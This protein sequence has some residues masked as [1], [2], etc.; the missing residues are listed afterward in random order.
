[1]T[2]AEA[3]MPKE[4][5]RSDDVGLIVM[6]F[7]FSNIACASIGFIAVSI[8]SAIASADDAPLA[9]RDRRI[10]AL[11]ESLASPNAEPQR[12]EPEKG[13]RHGFFKQFPA[14]YDHAAQK[15]VLEAVD[16]LVKEGVAAFPELVAHMND[17]RY[18]CT[19]KRPMSD[20][21]HSVGYVCREILER[22]TYAHEDYLKEGLAVYLAHPDTRWPE[23]VN[24]HKGRTLQ[25]VQLEATERTLKW[26]QDPTK[27]KGRPGKFPPT[28][29][30]VEKARV[31]NIIILENLIERL[32]AGETLTRPG[33]I[34]ARLQGF[35]KGP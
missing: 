12:A 3:R 15:R 28:A 25:G 16:G 14:D 35:R 13:N 27:V 2:N 8:A 5:R 22:Q 30:D 23:W 11:V 32:K 1:M 9:E 19:E 34:S 17:N 21:N 7:A 10:H 33:R 31:A 24:E 6:R 26:M 4:A 29:E 20:S 18:S